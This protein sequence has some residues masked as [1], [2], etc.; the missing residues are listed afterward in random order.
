MIYHT[1]PPPKIVPV[2]PLV[3]AVRLRVHLHFNVLLDN[4]GLLGRYLFL[5]LCYSVVLLKWD[6]V[7]ARVVVY[8]N[9]ALLRPVFLKRLMPQ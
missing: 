6:K 8:L 5:C 2:R 7:I 1:E 9:N 3:A 4:L